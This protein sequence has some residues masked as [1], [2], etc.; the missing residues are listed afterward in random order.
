MVGSHVPFGPAHCTQTSAY[1][2]AISGVRSLDMVSTTTISACG[3]RARMDFNA[4]SMVASA[5]RAIMQKD[6]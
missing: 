3:A 5:L 6:R 2:C 1:L 4:S